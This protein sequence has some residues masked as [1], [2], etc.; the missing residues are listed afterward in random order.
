[1]FHGWHRPCTCWPTMMN[2]NLSFDSRIRI[3]ILSLAAASIFGCT[4]SDSTN[5]TGGT[6]A[7]PIVNVA[8]CTSDNLL[9]FAPVGTG[10]RITQLPVG[11]YNYTWGETH[12]E[13][14]GHNPTMIMHLQDNSPNTQNYSGNLVC[15]TGA[16]APIALFDTGGYLFRFMTITG[17]N[18]NL[19]IT[20]Q[21]SVVSD[22]NT[23]TN[24]LTSDDQI[25]NLTNAEAVAK[26]DKVL[27]HCWFGE[28]DTLAVYQTGANTYRAILKR[29]STGPNG[30]T[31][32]F[33]VRADYT[34]IQ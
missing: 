20:R 27:N 30:I 23:I 2:T 33:H 32:R 12:I 9:P 4:S 10:Q 22:G 17:T 19:A 29:V 6:F 28:C 31:A 16:E 34:K 11:Q 1:M 25:L 15:L 14:I 21:L 13:T 8:G 5:G 26:E 3:L 18:F 7:V 24:T